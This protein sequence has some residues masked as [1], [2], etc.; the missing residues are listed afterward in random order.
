MARVQII[1]RV[2]TQTDRLEDPQE[3]DAKNI[4]MEAYGIVVKGAISR[5][6]IPWH[7]VHEVRQLP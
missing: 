7:R 5:L 6:T 4:D 2:D 3:H 1:L